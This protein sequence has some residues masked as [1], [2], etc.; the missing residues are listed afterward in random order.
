MNRNTHANL[1]HAGFPLTSSGVFTTF[2]NKQDKFASNAY[3]AVIGTLG[4]VSDC[5]VVQLNQKP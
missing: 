1:G 3:I 4:T 2:Y 5:T